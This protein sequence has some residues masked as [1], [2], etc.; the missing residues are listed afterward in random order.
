MSDVYWQGEG[1]V[2]SG[3]IQCLRHGM[4]G[5]SLATRVS[6]N[7]IGENNHNTSPP[8]FTLNLRHFESTRR[9]F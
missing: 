3:P 5:S 6:S 8:A 9:D 7:G 2:W 4:K 1:F